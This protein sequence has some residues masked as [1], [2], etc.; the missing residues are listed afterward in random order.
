MFVRKIGARILAGSL[1]VCLFPMAQPVAAQTL[2]SGERV[3]NEVC[4]VCHSAGVAG[5]PKFSDK[6]T[7]A[8][9]IAEGQPV[10]TAHA[11]VGVRGMPAKGGREDLRLEEFSRSVAFMA[12]AAGGSWKDPDA[13]M[14]VAISAEEKKRRADPARK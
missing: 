7:W 13:A 3:Y 11:W 6:A 8:P 5:A 12:R 9:L 14:L 10:L 1:F 4:A 2:K